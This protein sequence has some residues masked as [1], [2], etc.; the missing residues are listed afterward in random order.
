MKR[1]KAEGFV[2]TFKVMSM[3]KTIDFGQWLKV[4]S[5]LSPTMTDFAS[6]ANDCTVRLWDVQKEDIKCAK[7]IKVPKT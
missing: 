4:Q 6:T 2:A 7:I 3:M 1:C 5:R